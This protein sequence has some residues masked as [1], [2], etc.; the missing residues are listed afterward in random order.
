MPMYQQET[1]DA[2]GEAN[3]ISDLNN[4]GVPD[5]I[6]F[7]AVAG[8]YTTAVMAFEGSIDGTNWGAVVSVRLDTLGIE[9][10]PNMTNSAT[11]QWKVDCTGMKKFR[12]SLTSISTGSITC[13]IQ[14][15]A[16][17]VPVTVG[18]KPEVVRLTRSSLTLSP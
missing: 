16:V 14:T 15:T 5:N 6:A 2:N 1:L 13:T 4:V 17:P 11:R 18:V 8:T 3:T 9:D 12:A 7:V 10:T